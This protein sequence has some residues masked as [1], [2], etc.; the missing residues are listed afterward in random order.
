MAPTTAWACLALSV[1]LGTRI[2]RVPRIPLRNA[3]LVIA[4]LVATLA[5]VNI[6]APAMLDRALG[7][8][9]GQFGRV[10]L[11]VMSPVTAVALMLLALA[12]AAAGSRPSYA[13]PLAT[14]AGAV[15]AIVALGYAYGT[16]L[17][18]RSG[19]IPVALPTSISLLLLAGGAILTAGPRVWPLEALT[20]DAPRARMLRAFLPLTVGL[21]LL[22]GFLDAR[23]V[24]RYSGDQVLVAAWLAVVA[25]ALVAL[26]VSR[27]SRRIGRD[28]DRAY[29]EQNRAER[30]YRDLFEQSLAGVS[31]TRVSDGRI[32]I[33]NQR[34]AKIFGYE[35]VAEFLDVPAQDLWW[36]PA[37][38][39]R[40]LAPLREAGS[41]R[42]YEVHMRRKDGNA[43]WLLCNIALRRGDHREELL[44]NFVVDVSERKSLEQ[45][46]WQ[47]QK[48]DAL[49]SLAGGV[50]HDFNNL[51]TAII[52]YA[53]ILREDLGHSEHADDVNE[54]IKAS[55]RATALT[56]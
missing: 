25:A 48:L 37:D 28:I 40:M 6:I 55:D 3:G 17:L 23:Y 10:P 44:D 35:S 31:T 9:S 19:T 56:R 5:L 8:A 50:A 26:L 51:L 16:P 41:L 52:G 33:C 54:I 14:V 47:A 2:V 46:L 24:T 4:W 39:N 13:G 36:D 30:R 15:G 12:I 7:G 18:Y 22:I 42:N 20:G 1:A 49:G 38:R 32:L 21:V 29:V 27:L 11:G 53:D 34:L 45:Q 43:V